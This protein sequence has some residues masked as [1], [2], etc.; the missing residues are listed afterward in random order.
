MQTQLLKIQRKPNGKV[1]ALAKYVHEILKKTDFLESSI[2]F[3]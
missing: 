3:W 1:H 2:I